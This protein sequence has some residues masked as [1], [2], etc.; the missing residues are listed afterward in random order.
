MRSGDDKF[1]FEINCTKSKWQ[2]KTV[3]EIP[4]VVGRSFETEIKLRD[5]QPLIGT[6]HVK[7]WPIKKDEDIDEFIKAPSMLNEAFAEKV[8]RFKLP[9]G[10]MPKPWQP[11]KVKILAKGERISKYFGEDQVGT[12]QVEVSLKLFDCGHFYMKQTLPGSGISPHW[13]IFEGAWQHTARG[14]QLDYLIR[15]SWQV[16]RKPEIDFS[17]ECVPPV[18]SSTLAW[19]GDSETQLNGNIPAI[20]GE[21]R[22]CWVEIY[23]DADSSAKV[24]ARFNEDLDEDKPKEKKEARKD[25]VPREPFRSSWEEPPRRDAEQ[26]QASKRDRDSARGA[27]V[28]SKPMPGDDK[29]ETGESG[30]HQ[31]TAADGTKSSSSSDRPSQAPSKPVGRANDTQPVIVDNEPIWPLYVGLA[32]FVLMLAFFGW[33]QWQENSAPLKTSVNEGEAL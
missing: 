18:L 25:P 22:F 2:P 15:Y 31:R 7:K 23:R 9:D 12:R 24:A 21:D 29:R 6:D 10:L 16:S 17:I 27:E 8:I 4:K 19:E 28:K 20:V 26:S 30:L 14:L 32:L 13:V 1:H 33:L 5:I 3:P 11:K